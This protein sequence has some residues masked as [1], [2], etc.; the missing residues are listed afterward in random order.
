M[1]QPDKILKS[2]RLTEKSNFQSAEIGQYA[3]E[4][5]KTANKQAVAAAVEKVYEVEVRRVNILNQIGKPRR[6][7]RTGKSRGRSPGFKKA[8]VTLKQGHAI[9]HA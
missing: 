1:I 7:R 3:F 9:E 4:V 2:F 6:D 5:S 8:I